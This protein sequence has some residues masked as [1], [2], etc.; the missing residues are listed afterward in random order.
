MADFTKSL[1][2]IFRACYDPATHSLKVSS[3]GSG[4]YPEVANY[5]AL[6]PATAHS[7][8]I[9]AVLQ[10]Q[11][12]YIFGRK[13]RGFW[14]SDGATW[15]RLGDIPSYF[16]ADNFK[17]YDHIDN[18]KQIIWNISSVSP[19][20][21]RTITMPDHDVDLGATGGVPEAPI[22]GKQYAR[23]DASWVVVTGGGSMA[24]FDA[25]LDFSTGKQL[26][27][28]SIPDTAITT[29]MVIQPFYTN[30]LDEVAVLDMKVTEKSRTAGVGFELN[31]FAQNSAFGQYNVRCIVSGT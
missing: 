17:V 29:T 19:G 13:E 3:T 4:S 27:S 31:G 20:V 28:V 30:K 9:F 14:Y 15:S 18:T 10:S 7:G 23:K 5:G 11:G 12:L 21:T 22:D 24:T 8:E 16:D 2:D 26:V 6:P 1:E 25:V